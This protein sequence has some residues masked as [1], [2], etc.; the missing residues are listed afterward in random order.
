MHFLVS[1]NALERREASKGGKDVS[2]K[3]APSQPSTKSSAAAPK[4]QT[5]HNSQRND[6][7]I[8]NHWLRP[9]V[10]L[11]R[12]EGLRMMNRYLQL[13]TVMWNFQFKTFLRVNSIVNADH[14]GEVVNG[15]SWEREGLLLYEAKG[16]WD[17]VP[18]SSD[19]KFTSKVL[20]FG[21]I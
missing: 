16:Y 4:T 12:V 13:T 15:Q 11:L 8:T 7:R 10:Y 18:V 19:W 1:Y 5:S 3:S 6:I 9:L 20:Q 17:I 14:R 2:K 21:W